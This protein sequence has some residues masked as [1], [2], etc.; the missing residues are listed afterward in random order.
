MQNLWPVLLLIIYAVGLS[1]GQILFKLAS[2]EMVGQAGFRKFLI[3]LTSVPFYSGVIL[4]GFI[5]IFY[6]WL[7]TFIPLSRAYPFTAVAL[8]ITPVL[9]ALVFNESLSTS[10]I[11]GIVL[12][13]FGIILLQR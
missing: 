10:Y 13:G 4:Y 11:A 8:G 7:L 2:N 9:S 5:T 3:L 12:I 6:V 1:A